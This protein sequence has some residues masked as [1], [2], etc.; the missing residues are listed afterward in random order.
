MGGRTFR[1]A[2]WP[3]VQ[4]SVSAYASRATSLTMY[5]QNDEL[6]NV[7]IAWKEYGPLP[8]GTTGMSYAAAMAATLISSVNPPSVSSGTTYVS[9]VGSFS[10]RASDTYHMT[11]GCKISIERSSMSFRKPYFE[12]SCSPVVHF[13]VGSARLSCE[14]EKKSAS[15]VS[16]R[17]ALQLTSLCPSKSSGWRTSSHQ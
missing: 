15:A 1:L 3:R 5:S 13:R 2:S 14:R 11:S 12:Y 8:C 16:P 6:G 4:G 10:K 7:M 17:R 9:L